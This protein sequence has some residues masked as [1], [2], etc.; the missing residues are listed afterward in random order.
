MT[1]TNTNPAGNPIVTGLTNGTM[2]P[3]SVGIQQVSHGDEPVRHEASPPSAVQSA[4][5]A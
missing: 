2:T 1:P 5:T 4:A 3:V